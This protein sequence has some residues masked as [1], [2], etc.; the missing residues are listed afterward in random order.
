M[1]VLKEFR[2]MLVKEFVYQLKKIADSLI[3]PEHTPMCFALKGKIYTFERINQF[4]NSITFVVSRSSKRLSVQ[5]TLD[6]FENNKIS[7]KDTVWVDSG[8]L[9]DESFPITK[10][11][12]SSNAVYLF[13]NDL[14]VQEDTQTSA[15]LGTPPANT[16]GVLQ[17]TPDLGKN[18]DMIS[19]AIQEESK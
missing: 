13:I 12:K 15:S 1:I 16:K 19:K 6:F 3:I 5:D 11:K 9:N 18:K 4:V 17:L 2:V 10:I 8:V 7:D 14:F